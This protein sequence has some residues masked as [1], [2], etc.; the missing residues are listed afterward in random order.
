MRICPG[1][2]V[3]SIKLESVLD[4]SLE[5]VLSLAAEYDLM[6]TWNKYVVDA[7]VVAQPSIFDSYV[8]SATW[9]PFPFPLVDLLVRG[10]G[11]DLGQVLCCVFVRHV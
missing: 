3:H 7:T 9:L 8:Y 11:F 6:P 2:P 10:R 5:R 1:T 4:C